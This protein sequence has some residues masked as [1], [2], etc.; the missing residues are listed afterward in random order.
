MI[1]G[2]EVLILKDISKGQTALDGEYHKFFQSLTSFWQ[3]IPIFY[4][5]FAQNQ[6]GILKLGDEST[7]YLKLFLAL[8]NI[9]S[10]FEE[11][12]IVLKLQL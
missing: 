2:I 11:K 8:R 9:K 6:G 10:V 12:N 1:L 4:G 5:H 3:K 7:I